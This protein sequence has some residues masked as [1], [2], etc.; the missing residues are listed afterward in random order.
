VEWVCS[1]WAVYTETIGTESEDFAACFSC[2]G[3]CHVLA[4]ADSGNKRDGEL[5]Q[6]SKHLY[7]E[8]PAKVKNKPERVCVG[9]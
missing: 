3:F 5:L 9:W 8:K 6:F 2:H 7:S 4:D 1:T